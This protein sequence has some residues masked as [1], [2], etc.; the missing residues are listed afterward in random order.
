MQHKIVNIIGRAP[1][2]MQ[3]VSKKDTHFKAISTVY[4]QCCCGIQLIMAEST[5]KKLFMEATEITH[6]P[7]ID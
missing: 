7:R 4:S 2:Y 5:A 1:T 6:E 3:R